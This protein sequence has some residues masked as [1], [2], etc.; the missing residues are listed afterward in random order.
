MESF[1]KLLRRASVV[2]VCRQ[3][4]LSLKDMELV[5]D[6]CSSGS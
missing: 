2:E 6:P 5:A 1:H 4:D 3:R